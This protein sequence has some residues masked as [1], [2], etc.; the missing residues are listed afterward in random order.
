MESTMK[1]KYVRRII[2]QNHMRICIVT[3]LSRSALSTHPFGLLLNFFIHNRSELRMEAVISSD[4]NKK[5]E[6]E[7]WTDET[8]KKYAQKARILRKDN[9]SN[10]YIFQ[11]ERKEEENNQT[12]CDL[13]REKRDES[14]RM[15][16]KQPDLNDLWA[17][18]FFFSS[19]YFSGCFFFSFA[20]ANGMWKFWILKEWIRKQISHWLPVLIFFFLISCL[21]A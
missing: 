1:K 3:G 4:K 12:V 5:A 6:Y 15:K 18:F 21:N 16:S 7:E 19:S 2:N 8:K 9:L 14:A 11:K 17:R 10:L 13:D 20:F